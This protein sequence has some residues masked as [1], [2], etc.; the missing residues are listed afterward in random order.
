MATK[1]R[2]AALIVGALASVLVG[3]SSGKSAPRERGCA[4]SAKLVPSCGVIMGI[5][6]DPPT[7]DKLRAVETTLDTRFPMVHR[8]HDLSDPIPSDDERA[9]LANGRILQISIDARFYSRP[10]EVVTWAD[11]ASGKYDSL[12]R[13]QARGIASLGKP[14]FLT[15][16]HEPDLPRRTALGAPSQF[17]AAWRHTH[18]L[19][20]AAG[21]T[22]A[23]WVWVVTGSPITERFAIRTWP[24]NAYVDWISWESYNASGCREDDID[25]TKFRSFDETTLSFLH[26]LRAMYL[27]FDID[28][29]KPM[30]ISE[31]GSVMYPD[32]PGL[33]AKWYAQM[34]EVLAANPQIKAIGLWDRSGTASCDYRFDGSPQVVEAFRASA[35][36]IAFTRS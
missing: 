25:P 18:D 19:F 17:V 29:S 30:M 36:R 13:A 3:C 11:I 24:G 27:R 16:D 33:T 21:A 23:V 7:I 26:Y 22:N 32:D 2:P 35:G 31:A 28:L 34:G 14:V 4:L 12:L 1:L 6:T 8:F 15:F 9:L 10:D 5:Q 20:V